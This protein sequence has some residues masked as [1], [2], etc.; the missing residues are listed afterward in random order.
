ML[1]SER[2]L[3]LVILDPRAFLTT[4][5]VYH[6]NN[7]ALY[8]RGVI[9]RDW[10][11]IWSDYPPPALCVPGGS[12]RAR[13]QH[14][15]RMNAAQCTVRMAEHEDYR[16]IYIQFDE[17]QDRVAIGQVAAIWDGDWCLGCGIIDEVIQ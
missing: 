17:S 15:H 2:E 6:R 12:M 9:A 11:W 7:P 3:A 13:V 5:A 1:S 8:S 10:S 16:H 14:R 4:S